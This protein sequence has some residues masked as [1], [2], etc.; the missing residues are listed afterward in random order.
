MES[1]E[2]LFMSGVSGPCFTSIKQGS[3]N[4]CT[5]HLQLGLKRKPFAF[6]DCSSKATKRG[7]SLCYPVGYFDIKLGI[8]REGAAKVGKLFLLSGVPDLSP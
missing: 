4:H 6:P 5:V 7:A 8:T 3:Q 2:D 1:I